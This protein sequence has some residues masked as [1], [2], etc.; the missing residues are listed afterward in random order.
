MVD[1]ADRV[2]QYGVSLHAY[3]DDTQLYFYFCRNEV[4]PSVDQ[5]ERCVL[6]IGYWMSADR[7]K[8][9]TDKTERYSPADWQVSGTPPGADT[10][11][12]CSH[13]RLLGIYIFSD[14]SLSHLHGLLLPTSSTPTSPAVVGL[15]LVTHLRR[16]EFTD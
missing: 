6:D 10:T 13:V 9:N 2:A 12:V 4:A 3:A 5:L 7:L 8:V 14:L 15:R 1:L 11:I 16:C